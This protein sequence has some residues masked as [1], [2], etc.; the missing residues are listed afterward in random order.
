MHS[1]IWSWSACLNSSILI[2]WAWKSH[3]HDVQQAY[4]A[5]FRQRVNDLLREAQRQEQSLNLV[6]A[7]M[8]VWHLIEEE[9]A[10]TAPRQVP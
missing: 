7:E 10:Q 2:A 9:L 3:S 6:Q 8:Q 4:F 5:T 1:A